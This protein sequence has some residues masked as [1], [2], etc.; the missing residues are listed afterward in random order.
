MAR[1]TRSGGLA[2]PERLEFPGQWEHP[3]AIAP[4]AAQRPCRRQGHGF[5]RLGSCRTLLF[6][7]HTTDDDTWVS[8]AVHVAMIHTRRRDTSLQV[9]TGLDCTEAD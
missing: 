7:G 6:G 1:E 2:N 5:A 8:N 9:N 3:S 4:T